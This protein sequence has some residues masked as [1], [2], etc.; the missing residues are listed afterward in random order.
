M[1]EPAL[2]DRVEILVLVDNVT[3]SLSTAP[4]Y[5][6]RKTLAQYQRFIRRKPTSRGSD[7]S[8]SSRCSMAPSGETIVV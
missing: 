4:A 7:L 3:D 2:A 5:R 6:S 8:A 1:H